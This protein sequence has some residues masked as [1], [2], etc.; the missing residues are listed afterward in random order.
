MAAQL[1]PLQ[2]Q[3]RP[4]LPAAATAGRLIQLAVV[5]RLVGAP[6]LLQLHRWQPAG[7]IAMLAV[8]PLVE[9]CLPLQRLRRQPTAAVTV[10]LA[11]LLLLVTG[12][13]GAALLPPLFGRPPGRGLSLC[14]LLPQLRAVPAMAPATVSHPAQSVGAADLQSSAVWAEVPLPGPCL[15]IPQ[16]SRRSLLTSQITTQLPT[17]LDLCPCTSSHQQVELHQHAHVSRPCTSKF[18]KECVLATTPDQ[19]AFSVPKSTASLAPTCG[20]NCCGYIEAH[21]HHFG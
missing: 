8:L 13:G 11:G 6:L 19:H 1:G 10:N 21:L 2:E 3:R 16:R 5:I 18:M 9:V 4:Q 15:S 12:P 17:H 7:A 20:Q 14:L